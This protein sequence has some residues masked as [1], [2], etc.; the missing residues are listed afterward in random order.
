MK[1]LTEGLLAV[2]G[3]TLVLQRCCARYTTRVRT[4]ASPYNTTE[5]TMDRTL[6]LIDLLLD[7]LQLAALNMRFRIAKRRSEKARVEQRRGIAGLGTLHVSIRQPERVS[8]R[9]AHVMATR[10]H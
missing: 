4:D 2:V 9:P 8:R 1:P 10:L 5:N 7:R 6:D 3:L